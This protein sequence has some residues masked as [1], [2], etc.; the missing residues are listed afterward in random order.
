MRGAG[1]VFSWG[2]LFLF[3]NE[4]APPCQ[5]W[6]ELLQVYVT[7][8]CGTVEVGQRSFWELCAEECPG[9]QAGAAQQ[10]VGCAEW[11]HLRTFPLER[12]QA[13]NVGAASAGMSQ[14]EGNI[15]RLMLPCCCPGRPQLCEPPE[16]TH[17]PRQR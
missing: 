12:L 4:L 6:A 1:L 2:F 10:P 5:L 15:R 11:P 17:R 13:W 14:R 3:L 7:L 8:P 9:A 16:R